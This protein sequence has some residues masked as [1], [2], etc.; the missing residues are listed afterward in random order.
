MIAAMKKVSWSPC[1]SRA[2]A[3]GSAV[4]RDGSHDRQ[5]RV[6]LV[7]GKRGGGLVQ[8]QNPGGSRGILVQGARYGDPGLGRGRQ[9]GDGAAGIDVKAD[10]LEVVADLAAGLTE[11][12]RAEAAGEATDH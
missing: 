9:S 6:D 10:P 7:E 3:C 5:E 12:N 1:A 11:A 8:D 2:A 4:R